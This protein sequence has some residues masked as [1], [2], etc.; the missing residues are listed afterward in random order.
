VAKSKFQQ[1]LELLAII[2][3]TA[4]T[5]IE[6]CNANDAVPIF[7]VFRLVSQAKRLEAMFEVKKEVGQ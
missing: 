3:Q 1:T 2:R 7:D 6:Q 5:C 4:D